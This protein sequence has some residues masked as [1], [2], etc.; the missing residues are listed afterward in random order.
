MDSPI[1][2]IKDRLDIVDVISGYIKLTKTG[3]N[4]R[5]LCPFHS[6]SKPSFFVS[7]TR[8]LWRCFGCGLGGDIFAFVQQIEGIEFGDALRLLAQKAGVKL[9]KQDPQIQTQRKKIYELLEFAAKFYE[10][11]LQ[12]GK[13]GQKARQY[14]LQRGITE[15]SLKKWRIGFA[16]VSWN[17]LGDFLQ[18]KGFSICLI[19]RA[20]LLL[21]SKNG[22]IYDRFRARIIFPIFDLNSQI[23][24]FG[25]RFFGSLKKEEQE[26]AKYLNIP[27]TLLYNKSKILYGLD[28]AKVAIRK[29]DSCV[30]VEGYTDVILSHQAGVDNV[31]ATSGTAMTLPQLTILKRYSNNL[32]TA[33]D[34]DIA[35]GL[36]T[37]RGI[38]LAQSQ[39]FDIKVALLPEGKDPADVASLNKEQWNEIIEKSKTIL[40]FYFENAF[41]SFDKTLAQNKKKISSMLLPIINRIQNKI[42]QSHWLKKLATE[43]EVSEE[44]VN[45]ELSKYSSLSKEVE[46]Q[47]EK[48]HKPEKTRRSLIEDRIIALILNSPEHLKLLDDSAIICL[49]AQMRGIIKEFK[50]KP[51]DFWKNYA[52]LNLN[53]E[54]KEMLNEL[55]LVGEAEKSMEE[56]DSEKEIMACLGELTQIFKKDRLQEL[57]EKIKKAEMAKEAVK[58]KKLSKE[59][60][61]L[62]KSLFQ[63]SENHGVSAD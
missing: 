57:S 48:Y 54:Q 12:E 10:Q 39:G 55:A 41:S 19:K 53:E 42:E 32:I 21:E 23:V 63:E 27:N 36:A 18:K 62:A 61:E 58:V 33:F 17:S 13:N 52:D 2:E 1:Q 11:Q 59:F 6:E 43:L 60:N 20:G 8:Q 56:I 26:P 16:P 37:K 7:P 9:R 25:G 30:L 50:T 14:L 49:S 28:K 22:K 15:K 31:A 29:K 51:K 46:E 38:D 5:A 44:S 24:G 40:D 3:A 45:Q 34:M 4:Y 47:E 35:G